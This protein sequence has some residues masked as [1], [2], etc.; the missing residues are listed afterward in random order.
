MKD[1]FEVVFL[2]EAVKF[3]DDIEYMAREKMYYNIRK[4]QQINDNQILKK[5]NENIWE[6]R[7]INQNICYRLFA[8]WDKKDNKNTLIIATHGMIKK[9]QKTPAHEIDKAQQIRKK[10]LQQANGK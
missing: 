2:P 9:S 10:Y 4:A 3:M 1:R 7:C 6:F 8:F 5:L